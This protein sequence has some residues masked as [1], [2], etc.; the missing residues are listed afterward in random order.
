MLGVEHF[1]G[2]S[3]AFG[4]LF[5]ERFERSTEEGLGLKSTVAKSSMALMHLSLLLGVESRIELWHLRSSA[6]DNDK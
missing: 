2:L 6:G 3:S 4:G 1:G 5:R